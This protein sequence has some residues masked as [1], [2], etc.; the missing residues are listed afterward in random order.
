VAELA[1][2]II[3][4]GPR[5]SGFVLVIRPERPKQLLQKGAVLLAELAFDA[6]SG[7]H[8]VTPSQF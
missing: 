8:G 2:Q 7:V 6:A 5:R 3:D 1:Q 4:G